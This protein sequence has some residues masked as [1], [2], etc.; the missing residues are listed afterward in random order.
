MIFPINKKATLPILKMELIKD[1]RNDFHKFHEMIQ[2]S[3][4]Y[5]CM[6][7]LDTGKKIIGKAPALCMLKEGIE[8]D[9]CI[10]EEY[11]LAYQ[12]S[13][14]ETSKSGTYVGEFIIN[15]L[16]GSGTLKVPIRDTLYVHVLDHGIKK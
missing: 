4:I 16:D 1:G 15:F 9:D 11:Y 3:D 2:N 5:F 8:D 6:S 13:E 7:E 12:F 14:K 10:G